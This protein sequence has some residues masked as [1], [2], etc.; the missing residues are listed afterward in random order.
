MSRIGRQPINIPEGVKIEI[1]KTLIKVSGPKGTVEYRIP[2]AIIVKTEGQNLILKSQD[3]SRMS[4][5]LLGTCR[6]I[7]A[8][9]VKGASES[10]MKELE[11]VG[12]GFRA[13]VSGDTLVLNLGFSHPVKI[14]APAGINFKVEKNMI[15]VEGADKD[16]VGLIASRIRDAKPPEPYKGKGIMYKGEV[17]RRKAGKA[18]K[19]Q[20]A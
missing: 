8:N 17:I 9:M 14:K 6:S 15:G 10:W 12:T 1:E 4:N 16:K 3:E 2:Q 5:S 7:I 18:A 19:A 20:M 11:L 13:E